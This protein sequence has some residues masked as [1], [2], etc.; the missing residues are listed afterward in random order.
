MI[1]RIKE[2]EKKHKFNYGILLLIIISIILI[3]LIILILIL[4]YLYPFDLI[5]KPGFNQSKEISSSYLSTDL[6][7]LYL[8]IETENISTI[9]NNS[10]VKVMMKNNNGTIY[11]YNINKTTS[12][13]ILDEVSIPKNKK[14]FSFLSKQEDYKY[15][16][17]ISLSE[18][19]GLVSFN[20]ISQ[21]K[22]FFEANTTLPVIASEI[23]N[24]TKNET[25]HINKTV[26]KK[27]I[28]P[29]PSSSESSSTT[30]RNTN[31][32]DTTT[33]CT[34]TTAWQNQNQFQCISEAREQKQARIVCPSGNSENRWISS[35]CDEGYRC[36]DG[37]GFPGEKCIN[38]SLYCMD[39]DNGVNNTINGFLNISNNIYNDSCF[40][41][42]TLT[43]YY[44]LYNGTNFIADNQT[45]NCTFSC[46]DGACVVC[47]DIDNDGYS[48]DG[49]NCREIDCNDN[50]ANINPGKA[51]VCE[52]AIDE[53][54]DNVII[55]INLNQSLIAYYKFNDSLDD[56]SALDETGLYS[57]SC[58]N[59]P[60]Y[61]KT[62][63]LN[64]SGSYEFNGNSNS[65]VIPSVILNNV[66][67][68]LSLW[69]YPKTTST[70][71]MIIYSNAG[72]FTKGFLSIWFD[73]NRNSLNIYNNYGLDYQT[74]ID[75]IAPN[76]WANI[77][78]IYDY[79]NIQAKLYI[80]GVLKTTIV[81]F[82]Q[83]PQPLLLIIGAKINQ[84]YF[85]GNMAEFRVYNR[86]L[87]SDEV[88]YLSNEF[89]G[90]LPSL[91][92]FDIE[93][94]DTIIFYG[95]VLLIILVIIFLIF[96]ILMRLYR[97][98]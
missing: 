26:T 20:E 33:S 4:F 87:T 79:T 13:L 63:G 35:S 73:G 50:N 97:K 95:I 6:N 56:N 27:K 22:I 88:A 89:I 29:S 75:S 9:I 17:K 1:E 12:Q 40:E 61:N 3:V 69:I 44:C 47:S 70:D 64:N 66:S 24:Q 98:E 54:C 59:C 11:Y 10:M 77:I 43:E 18:I 96:Y 41:N 23:V 8:K 57:A 45:S 74:P 85:K 58:I 72:S 68:S 82:Q 92:L 53:N 14:I 42:K 39:S 36:Y 62:F 32:Q 86:T 90:G 65:L 60:I 48:S 16:I 94:D 93:I 78:F 80:N 55:C 21:I 38:N 28:T 5:K 51:E 30:N 19:N 31:D 49:G 91:S 46:L 2:G 7:N 71:S 67:Y 15:N 81:N 34:T 84:K 83:A 76:E 25:K 52:N 37:L